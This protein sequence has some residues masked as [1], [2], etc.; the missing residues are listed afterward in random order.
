MPLL[1]YTLKGFYR[2][3]KRD[4]PWRYTTDPYRIL[5]SELMLQQTQVER[6]V[7]YYTKFVRT[8]PGAR[9]L[10]RAKLPRILLLWQGLGYNRRAKYLHA[11][12]KVV[13]KK[14]FPRIATDIEELPGV[15]RYTA[16][17][18]AVFAYNDAEVLIE[19]NIRTVFVYHFFRTKRSVDDK[20][21]LPLIEEALKSSGMEPRDFYAALMDYGAHLKKSG[22]RLNTKSAHYAK[23]SRFQGSTRQ[24]RG[25]I[26]RELLRH[27]ATLSMLT[28][29][30]PVGHN[31]ITHEL[32]R[33]CA[34]GLVSIRGRYFAIP[35]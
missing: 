14:G 11:A 34:E 18:V 29:K 23:Q 26:L 32:A 30:I 12:A 22:V 20:K 4:L 1:L 27:H 33:L 24:L 16:R 21:I 7:P 31:D 2:R 35:D 17:A 19:T 13:A 9:S 15:G 25:S 8:F 6:V 5:V 10:A 3:N 28:H